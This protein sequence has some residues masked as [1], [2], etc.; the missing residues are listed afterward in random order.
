MLTISFCSNKLAW[1]PAAA[2]HVSKNA[3]QNTSSVLYEVILELNTTYT[4]LKI[5]SSDNNYK[6]INMILLIYPSVGIR[7]MKVEL[8]FSLMWTQF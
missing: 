3:L 4:Q 8:V 7:S 2:E 5:N 6:C 1:L